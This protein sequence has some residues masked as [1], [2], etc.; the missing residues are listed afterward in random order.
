MFNPQIVLS[1]LRDLYKK[2]KLRIQSILDHES[3]KSL[4]NA[5]QHEIEFETAVYFDKQNRMLSDKAWSALPQTQKQSISKQIMN[6]AA[7]GTGF[8]YGRKKIDQDETNPLLRQAFH[9][10]NSETFLEEMR[11]LS[12][13]EELNYASMQATRFM[14]GQFITRHNDVVEAEGRRLA[15]V[16]N[17]TPQWHPDW[18]GLLQ[19]FNNDGSTLQSWTPSFNTLSLFGVNN[20]HS[21]TYVTP[22]AKTPRYSITGWFGVR[23]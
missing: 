6:N 13:Y 21:V 9:T 1:D 3:S 22:F 11:Q 16:F 4:S 12:G 19:F 10:L 20:I 23:K 8:I 2:E 17:L 18:G 14:P 5:L 7:N 15:Y